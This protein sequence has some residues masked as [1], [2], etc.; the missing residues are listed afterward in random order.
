MDSVT[1]SNNISTGGYGAS[2]NV[3]GSDISDKHV[4]IFNSTIS[5]NTTTGGPAAGIY[6]FHID[7]VTIISTEILDNSG[8]STGGLKIQQVNYFNMSN[9]L[10]AENIGE[11]YGGVSFLSTGPSLSS[12]C[13]PCHCGCHRYHCRKRLG[14]QHL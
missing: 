5:D 8:G 12:R 7:S 3:M 6:I 9:S 4:R 14:C 2:I 1:V 11:Y 10:V 13:N